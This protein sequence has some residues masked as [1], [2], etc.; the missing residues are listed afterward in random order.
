MT[1]QEVRVRYLGT[2]GGFTWAIANPLILLIVYWLVFSVLLNSRSEGQSAF[3]VP[4]ACG[5]IPWTTF[6]EILSSSCYCI[7]NKPHLVTKTVFPTE[8]LPIVTVLAALITHGIMLMVLFVILIANGVN[9]SIWW[10]QMVYYLI[11]LSI[12]SLGFG[13]LLAAFNV[14]FKDVA[15]TINVIL[16][17]WFWLTPIVWSPSV[18]PEPLRWLL[19]L[20]PIYYIV[21]GYRRTFIHHKPLWEDPTGLVVFWTMCLLVLATGAYF[22]R[23]LKPEFAEMI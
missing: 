12:F 23:R 1:W 10:L 2:L 4:F 18:V 20:N 19:R 8:I 22:F 11:S 14:F 7:T 21:E 13:W 17:I 15:Q 5:F 3:I 6:S 16:S 9:V